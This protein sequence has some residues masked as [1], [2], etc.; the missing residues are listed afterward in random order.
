MK[1]ISFVKIS[2][3][4]S[5]RIR[6]LLFVIVLISAVSVKFHPLNLINYFFPGALRN[7]SS[8]IMLN[9]FSIPCPFCGMSRSFKEF[10]S[11]NLSGSFYYNPSSVFVFLFLG[12]LFLS[13]FVLS[14]FNYKIL[15][16]FNNKTL[17]LLILVI[18]TIWTINILYGH[19]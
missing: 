18:L 19:I 14:L 3:A 4:Q 1:L 6:L 7:D 5:N 12:L 8:C 16:R 10:V 13:I 11:M 2:K 9:L 17:L 15:F